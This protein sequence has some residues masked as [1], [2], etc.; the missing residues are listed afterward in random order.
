MKFQPTGNRVV[1]SLD[2]VGDKTEGGLFIPATVN[3]ADGPKKGTVK[4]VSRH[5]RVNGIEIES[6][7]EVDDRVLVDALGGTVVRVEGSDFL[8]VRNEDILGKFVE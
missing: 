2:E 8:C 1:I 6:H 5:Y 7:F 4:S 3:P